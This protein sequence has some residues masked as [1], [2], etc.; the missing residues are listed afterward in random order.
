MY[1]ARVCMR[2]PRIHAR[3]YCVVGPK[4]VDAS[5]KLPNT[6]LLYGAAR[7]LSTNGHTAECTWNVRPWLCLST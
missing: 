7:S 1:M 3:A 2:T 6:L 5:D 4:L